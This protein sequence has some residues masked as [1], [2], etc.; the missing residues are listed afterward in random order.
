VLEP[1][2]TW[3]YACAMPTAAGQTV[4][5]NT[6]TATGTNE[7]GKTA[8]GTDAAEIPLTQP[9]VPDPPAQQPP[10]QSP[11]PAVAPNAVPPA[12]TP[13]GGVL[14]E[15]IVSGR[16]QLRGPSGCVK[17]AFRARVRGRAIASV[18]FFVDGDRAKRVRAGR[19]FMLRVE[20][21]RYGF[22]RHRVTAIVRFRAESATRARTL[23]LT[24]RRCAQRPVA[25]RFMG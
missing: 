9:P 24:F 14:P 18:T 15:S 21:S 16:A 19:A 17:R 1:G 23:R 11:P 13:D 12:T 5:Q 7:D 22:G 6:A 20:P 2:E 25:P 8:T 10:A 4:A 3:T